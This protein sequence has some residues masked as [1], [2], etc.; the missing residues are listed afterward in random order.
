MAN[1]QA[2]SP[3]GYNIEDRPY[4]DNP[5]WEHE[6]G[7]VAATVDVGTV[8]TQTLGS[9]VPASVSITNSGDQENAVFDFE[10][11]IPTGPKGDTG[12]TGSQGPR[13]F[14][15]PIGPQGPRGLT[16]S[17]GEKGEKGDTGE[18]GPAG[19]NG[20]TPRISVLA[21]VLPIAGQPGVNVTSSGTDETPNYK[22]NF[23]GLG[24]E[25]GDTG[26]T[27]DMTINA[28]I[29]PTA[30]IPNVE[31]EKSGTPEEPVFD[32]EFSG[33]KGTGPDL[34]I[35]ASILPIGGIPNVEVEKHNIDADHVTYDM[36][37]SGIKGEKGDTGATGAQGPQGIQGI[38][39]ETGATGAT[40]PAGPGVPTGGTAGQ[41]LSKVD[42]TDYNTQWTTLS[43]DT[44]KT[45]S[46]IFFR[47]RVAGSSMSA[48]IL[49]ES[50]FAA[51]YTAGHKFL[52]AIVSFFANGI[53]YTTS[54][55]KLIPLFKN[56]SDFKDYQGNMS[57]PCI[58]NSQREIGRVSYSF[59]K[60]YETNKLDFSLYAQYID[61]N[62]ATDIPGSISV[63][64]YA[65]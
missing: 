34:T 57:I 1:N 5:F 9:G 30:G 64:L 62:G 33:L 20:K 48:N 12:A 21:S 15:G 59:I 58:I 7:E 24:G 36:T 6:T 14:E 51:L 56:V 54:E 38:Q 11:N 22:F 29:L 42:G 47:N 49:S 8:R 26:A 18:Q 19:E 43:I 63:Q 50:Q 55:T 25:K 45:P 41:F 35:N 53:A 44:F 32:L 65:I 52:F 16:G 60:T 23:W 39:G 40:G 2:M 27:P 17:R 31:I 37:F 28:S 10:F 4:N 3:Q 61:G 13:G 46:Q